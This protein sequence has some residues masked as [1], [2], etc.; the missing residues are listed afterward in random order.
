MDTGSRMAYPSCLRIY[1]TADCLL[2]TASSMVC[3]FAVGNQFVDG[4]FEVGDA[5]RGAGFDVAA[6]EGFCA[7]GA[8][9]E[10]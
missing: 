7:G 9:E 4:V 1:P 2:P 10:P 3:W 6:D 8:N 5:L